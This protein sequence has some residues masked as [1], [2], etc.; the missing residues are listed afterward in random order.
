VEQ[1]HADEIEELRTL[2]RWEFAGSGISHSTGRRIF[3]PTVVV[4]ECNQ[5]SGP[6]EHRACLFFN[7]T[8]AVI[9]ANLSRE[10]GLLG[11]GYRFLDERESLPGLIGAAINLNQHFAIV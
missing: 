8:Q 9:T 11:S 5:G 10:R 7:N 4:A 1:V 2:S 6:S 3:R